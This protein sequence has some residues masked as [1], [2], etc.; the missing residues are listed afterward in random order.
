MARPDRSTATSR[1]VGKILSEPL[2]W[3]P[4]LPVAAAYSFVGAPGWLCTSAAGVI[5]AGL[6]AW[7]KRIWPSVYRQTR[8]DLLRSWLEAENRKATFTLNTLTGQ[9]RWGR[10]DLP[11]R[12]TPGLISETFKR[13]K[14]IEAKILEDGLLT[15]EEEE[16]SQNIG[17]LFQNIL[18][19]LNALALRDP[20][21][22]PEKSIAAIATACDTIRAAAE[23][24]DS[25]IDPVAG[26]GL[27]GLEEKT[28]P[29]ERNTE[30]LKERMQ[31]A[32]AIRRR[33]SA[34]LNPEPPSESQPPA[35]ETE[36]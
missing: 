7:W 28:T 21:A 13:K 14:L 16:L 4:F 5:G 8:I 29:I 11:G 6:V 20:A 19:E 12:V 17:D 32:A 33:V 25:L 30:R 23:E 3:L 10:N 15:D 27:E 24:V 22:D 31:Q 1:T 9:I 34:T 26:I 2:T 18:N 36:H 35:A